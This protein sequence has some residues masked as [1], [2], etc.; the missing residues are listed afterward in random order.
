MSARCG[1]GE[2]SRE[3]GRVG[4]D[5]LSVFPKM[6]L[7]GYRHNHLNLGFW[8]PLSKTRVG[9]VKADN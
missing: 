3:M 6:G 2:S 9:Q 8:R 1:R 5:P 4:F 7:T